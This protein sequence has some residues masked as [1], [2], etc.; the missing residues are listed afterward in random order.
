MPFGA[1]VTMR[2][3][4]GGSEPRG[5]GAPPGKPAR[6]AS[7]YRRLLFFWV[8]PLVVIA[9]GVS[10]AASNFIVSPADVA[11]RTAPPTPSPILIPVEMREL[12]S[13]I[14]TRGTGRFGL[15][16]DVSISPSGLKPSAGVI[17]T[18]PMLNTQLQEGQVLL[19]A[20]G[21]PVF[22]LQGDTPAYR[23]I[24]RGNSGDDVRQLEEALLRLGFDPGPVDGVFDAS[25][26]AAVAAWYGA[27]GWE[28]FAPTPA[29]LEGLRA[30]ESSLEDAEKARAAAIAG[31][32]D[33]VAKLETAQ[34]EATHE[35]RR[36]E[37]GLEAKTFE[38]QRL[39]GE[40]GDESLPLAAAK[41]KALYLF[42]Q[43]QVALDAAT[44]ERDAVLGDPQQADLSRVAAQ[45][46]YDLAKAAL[47]QA[48]IDGKLGIEA[49]ERE[50][51]LAAID[52]QLAQ[53]AAKA[54]RQAGEAKIRAAN[55]AR[56]LAEQD[57]DLAAKAYDRIAGELEAEKSKLGVQVPIDEIVFIPSL[58][59]RVE[60]LKATVG[61]EAKGPL[62]SVTDNQLSIDST[63]T[64]ETAPLVEPGMPVLID[65]QALGIKAKGVVQSVASTP[66][67]QG[68]DGYHVY[69]EVRVLE[70]T[71]RLEN[72]SVRLTIPTQSTAG[73][74]LALPV[75]AVSLAGDG[76]SRVQVER[77]G[78]FEFVVVEPG[79]SADGYVAVTPLGGS[80]S[81][82]DLVVVGYEYPEP[83]EE[84]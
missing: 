8:L 13:E 64:L 54:A 58:P 15:P 55:D 38:M 79:M 4:P 34:T 6:G 40:G 37:A 31:V 30:L 66:G 33:A 83:L 18:L 49:V 26:S 47:E 16:Q 11:A 43:A 60:E 57:R 42:Q 35:N 24:T 76:T 52:H 21:R 77:N 1:A 7:S 61:Q 65:E 19:T 74:V 53:D 20:S 41:A 59:V 56:K 63:L 17:T 70:T 62:L 22:I 50:A 25:A 28:P 67:T 14:I 51:K 12:G 29:Q 46:K 73:E 5:S 44:A 39:L 36:A 48:R 2:I 72:V 82:G 23:D 75:S 80:L 32:S 3:E 69:F 10:W 78:Q 45:S 71:G 9:L 68:A 27:G 81:E 84:Q